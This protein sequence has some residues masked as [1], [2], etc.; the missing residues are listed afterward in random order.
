MKS[1]DYIEGRRAFMEKRAP[2]F[3]A[4]SQSPHATCRTA[5]RTS[6]QVHLPADNPNTYTD[7]SGEGDMKNKIIALSAAC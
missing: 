1:E 3:K 5:Y 4:N 2:Q 6:C 7:N